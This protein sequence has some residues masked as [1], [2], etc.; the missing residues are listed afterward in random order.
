MNVNSYFNAIVLYRVTDSG[1]MVVSSVERR[2]GSGEAG[3]DEDVISAL[4]VLLGSLQT[5]LG[6][7]IERIATIERC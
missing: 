3:R 4:G 6:A 5:L 7:N 2:C 1:K